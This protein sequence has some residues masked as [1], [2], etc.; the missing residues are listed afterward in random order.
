M[1]MPTYVAKDPVAHLNKEEKIELLVRAFIEA[2]YRS[3]RVV[4]FN[5]H[6]LVHVIRF[7]IGSLNRV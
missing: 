1:H 7:K 6:A 4:L 2:L 5:K 3:G